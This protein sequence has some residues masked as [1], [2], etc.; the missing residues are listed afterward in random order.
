V[1]VP[2]PATGA[3]TYYPINFAEMVIV[4]IR[5]FVKIANAIPAGLMQGPV[6]RTLMNPL[7]LVISVVAQLTHV[8]RI[9]YS[10]RTIAELAGL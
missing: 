7:A 4:S 2:L 8:M 10:G 6:N 3:S 9:G 5:T 1:T